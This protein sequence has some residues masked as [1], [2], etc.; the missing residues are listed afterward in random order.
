MS[1]LRRL[2]VAA[3]ARAAFLLPLV[4]LGASACGSDSGGGTTAA[5]DRP[6][7]T[8]AQFVQR[9][10]GVCIRSDRRVYRIGSLGRDAGPWLRTRNAAST[11]VAEMAALRPPAAKQKQFDQMLAAGGRL[12]D[13]VGQVH[14]A[15]VA[16]TYD[17]AQQGQAEAVRADAE[18]KRLAHALGLTFCE[19]LLTNW[20]A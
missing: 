16:K 7:L 13:A 9:A 12:R 8:Q 10:N 14:D 2:R 17:K 20:P 18:V 11:A 19:Q 3:P 1:R 15:L 4:A 6:R 5:K